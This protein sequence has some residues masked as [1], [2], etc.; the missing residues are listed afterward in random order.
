MSFSVNFTIPFIAG[1]SVHRQKII[2]V[3]KQLRKLLGGSR[4][5]GAKSRGAKSG[6]QRAVR[7]VHEKG[8]RR[9]GGSV[10]TSAVEQAKFNKL[11][12]STEKLFELKLT[13]LT[14]GFYVTSI[15]FI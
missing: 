6:G 5:L 9:Q 8:D 14:S 1:T 10:S 2:R 11:F 13:E 3:I 15:A 7:R 4:E 12:F